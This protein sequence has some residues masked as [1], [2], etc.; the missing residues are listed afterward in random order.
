MHHKLAASANQHH[1]HLKQFTQHLGPKH[2]H[3]QMMKTGLIL[4]GMT[5]LRT[6]QW[7]VQ[8]QLLTPTTM[9]LMQLKPVV[10]A[11]TKQH[12]LHQA[13]AQTMRT[14]WTH[15]GTRVLFTLLPSVPMLLHMQVQMESMQHKRVVCAKMKQQPSQQAQQNQRL[16]VQNQRVAQMMRTGWTHWDTHVLFILLWSVPMLLY[17]QAQM[18][19]MQQQPAVYAKKEQWRSQLFH[20]NQPERQ[21]Q[22]KQPEPAQVPQIVLMMTIGWTH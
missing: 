1:L 14:G 11:K 7:N 12:H 15:W 13:V 17:T 9:E 16:K 4:W 8:L 5:A 10:S 18:E 21:K 20:Q 22:P 2:P 19:S 3:A 6:Q